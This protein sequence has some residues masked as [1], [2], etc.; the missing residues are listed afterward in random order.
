ML[1]SELVKNL[2]I[3]GLGP[4]AMLLAAFFYGQSIANK[5]NELEKR[6]DQEARQAEANKAMQKVQSLED[7]RHSKIEEIRAA[8]TIDKL[9][10]LWNKGPWGKKD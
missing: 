9:V 7:D 4:L 8:E 5:S 1:V 10:E 2:L 6:K 3:Y